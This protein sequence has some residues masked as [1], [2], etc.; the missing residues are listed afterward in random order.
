VKLSAGQVE[1]FLRRPDPQIRAVLLFGPDAGLVR[2]RADILARAVCPDLRDPFRVAE[3]TA[4]TLAADP[5][6]LADEAAQISLMGGR[7]VVRLR[8]AGDQQSPLLARF[9]ADMPGDALVIAEAGDLPGRSALRRA[10]DD[11]TQAAAIGCYPDNARDL[12]AVIRDTFAAQ[13]IAIS[14]DAVAFLVAHLGGDRL[15]TRAELEKLAL[16]AGAGG[17]I[18]LADA[19]AVISDSAA[20][21]LDDAVLAAAEGDAAA[22]DRALARVFQEGEAAVTIIRALL[23]HLHRLHVL[24]AQLA[25]GGSIDNVIRSARPPIFFKQQDSWRRQLQRWTEPRLREALDRVA[26]T[27]FSMKQTG[28]PAETLCREAMFAITQMARAGPRSAAA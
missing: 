11:S 24:A 6:R 21:S 5:A 20:L 16:Y 10:F 15:L 25:A 7:R 18:E 17:R 19:Q 27:E 4:A 13:K 1:G 12:A 26:V 8:D 22:L 28:L 2:E 23:R 9:L 14:R 3:L